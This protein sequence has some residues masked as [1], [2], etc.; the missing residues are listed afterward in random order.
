MRPILC[1]IS[2]FLFAGSL[3]AQVDSI[4]AKKTTRPY[5]ITKDNGTEYIGEIISDDGR[6]VLIETINLGKIYIP[7]SEIKNMVRVEDKKDI[8]N[9]E[10]RSS[11]PFTTRYIFTNNALPIKK[12][13]NY[14]MINLFGPE[15]HFA[16]SNNF[17][18]GVMAT[19]IGSPLVVAMKYTFRTTDSKLNF[20]AGTLLG[21]T[22]YLGRFRDNGALHWLSMTIG[23]R[24]NNFTLSG[25]YGYVQYNYNNKLLNEG[26]YYNTWPSSFSGRVPLT[27]GPLFSLAGIIKVGSKASIVFDSMV[28]M[29]QKLKSRTEYNQISAGYYN[30]GQYIDAVYTNTVTNTKYYTSA[31][32]IM[33]GMRFQKSEKKAFQ[34]SLASVLSFSA[35]N[36][37]FP[38]PMCSW[39]HKF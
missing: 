23:D 3:I 38:F 15:V 14:S 6:E 27:R 9:G 4:D 5:V 31:L 8:V 35:T 33:P 16:V 10:Y 22:G 17:N 7:K 11:G 26:V 1:F 32:L 29:F 28:F 20:S 25:G 39:F 13:E 37:V 12:G 21:S 19:W 36:T 24:M 2:F 30:G 34:I 18:I